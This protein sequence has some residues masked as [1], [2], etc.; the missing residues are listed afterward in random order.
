MMHRIESLEALGLTK[1]FNNQEMLLYG[2][3]IFARFKVT[4]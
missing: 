3:H 4:R 2:V 1:C